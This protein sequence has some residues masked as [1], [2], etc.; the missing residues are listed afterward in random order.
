VKRATSIG[1]AALV[2]GV[3]L[4]ACGAD[5][6]DFR[7]SAERFIEGDRMASESGT[8]FTD[9]VCQEP[10]STTAGTTFRCVATDARGTEWS[11]DVSIVDDSNFQ[12]T[13]SHSA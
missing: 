9:A 5:T 1:G 6:A 3:I 11:F 7:A 10:A 4:A 2:L 12:I 13:G 8:T